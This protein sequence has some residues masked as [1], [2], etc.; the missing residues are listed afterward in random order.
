MRIESIELSWFRGAAKLVALALNSKSMVVYG[1]N[2]SG[3]SSFVDA[4]EY[5]LNDGKVG[6]LIHEYSGRNQEKGIINTHTPVGSRVKLGIKFKDGS[7]RKTMISRK[8]ARLSS[9][10]ENVAVNS[11]EYRRTVLRQDELADFIRARKG[12]KYSALLPLLGL[13]QL[14]VAAENIRQLA[15]VV[16]QQSGLSEIRTSLKKVATKREQLFGAANEDH[17]VKIIQD[18][19]TKYCVKMTETTEP[20]SRCNEIETALTA[21]KTG[22]TEDQRRHFILQT[23]AEIELG[24]HIDAV[25]KA[26]TELAGAVEPLISEK[27]EILHSTEAFV[28]GLA[29]EREVNCPACG[30]SIPVDLFQ[31]HVAA[32]KE[33]L[34]DA[35]DAFNSR[36]ETIGTLCEMV[37]SLKSSM[38]KADIKT[39][40]DDLT[41]SGILTENFTYLSDFNVED[42][43][44]SCSN[45]DLKNIGD[46]LQPL[47]NAASQSSEEAPPD[48]QQ[49]AT[50]TEIVEACKAIVDS[51]ELSDAANRADDLIS[52]LNS[53]EQGIRDEIREQARKV[54]DE[55]SSDI[56]S[57]WAILHPDEAIENVRLSI[58]S[59]TDKA[60]D[61]GLKFYGV[62]QDSPRLT[63]SEGYRNSLGLCI[64]LAMAKKEADNDRPLF[65]DDIVV[66]FDQNHKGM[67][68]ELLG[69][70][71]SSRQVIIFTHDRVWYSELR[72]QL[73]RTNWA[74]KVLRPYETPEIGI[75][76]S[77]KTSTFDDARAHLAERPDSAGNDVR[78]IMD[79]ELALIAERLQVKLPYQRGDRN[80]KRM[81]HDFLERLLA[82]SKK[83][84]QMKSGAEYV[85][86]TSA[87]EVLDKVDRL[88][89]SW[90]N[91]GSHTFELARSEANKLID[92]CEQ[93]LGFFRCTSCGRDVWYTH[94]ERTE[95][96]QCEC[97]NLRWRYGKG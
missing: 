19:H 76:L 7:A 18:L 35:I 70:E 25:R 71:F 43:R 86:F 72:H 73:D 38:D 16:K 50:D 42:L 46:N 1:E 59:D 8:G 23:A 21:R 55:I 81:A 22:L 61:I 94:V 85:V 33:R 20:T 47:I 53:L 17:I 24:E 95:S 87:I 14:E 77:E 62:E 75:R 9:G 39:W 84:F 5:I 63:L 41:I 26:N 58:P 29:D 15:R 4:V 34:Q 89:L 2:G 82:D 30:R 88:L 28:D 40:R 64:F 96:R 66:S 31:E 79:F 69:Q 3:K 27:L 93:A 74:F 60:I 45:D 78:K 54:I 57:M 80:D 90:A 83:C 92:D 51:K 11:W 13:H 97:S 68:V 91:R 56:Q 36:K 65:L 48:V 12:E 44:T 10:A 37:A 32:E 67:I 49:L 6:H 52:F